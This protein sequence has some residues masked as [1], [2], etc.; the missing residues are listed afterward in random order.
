MVFE[1]V[2]MTGTRLVFAVVGVGM[3]ALIGAGVAHLGVGNSAII[4]GGIVGGLVFLLG[5]RRG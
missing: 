2:T 5:L 3:G 1:N 4:A